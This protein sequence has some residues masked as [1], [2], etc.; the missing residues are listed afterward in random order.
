M[1]G[2]SQGEFLFEGIEEPDPGNLDAWYLSRGIHVIAG[3]DE[4]G[5]GALAG[6]VSAGAVILGNTEIE[7]LNDSKKLTPARREL[8][9]EEIWDRA[10]AVGVAMVS[11]DVIDRVNILNAALEAMR[12][13]VGMLIGDPEIVLV[14]GNQIPPGIENPVAVVK[15]DTRSRSIMA[16][17]IVAKV[18]RDRWMVKAAERYPGYG[19]E[20]HKGYCVKGHVDAIR[21]LGPSVIHRMTFSPCSEFTG[22]LPQGDKTYKIGPRGTRGH[23][24]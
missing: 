7:G 20:K 1:S 16:A 12:L 11:S 17:S 15:G 21:K 18:T 19:L 4:A 3:V 14:D 6:P 22:D 2:P 10:E 13:S 8:V 24:G 23:S 5:R 9:F